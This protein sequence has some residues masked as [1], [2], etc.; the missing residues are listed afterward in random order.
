MS[1]RLNDLSIVVTGAGRGIGAEIARAFAAEGA[2]IVVADLSGESAAN[3]AG[4]ISACGGRAIATEVDVRKRASIRAMVAMAVD[5]FGG[6]DSIVNNAGIAQVR[7][8]LEITDED[9]DNVIQVN[10]RGV[11]IC[12]QEAIKQMISQ[13]RGGTVINMGSIAGKQ[14]YPTQAHYCAS[15][16]GVVALTQAGAKAFGANGIRVNAICPGIVATEMWK[17]I[18]QS[19]RDHGLTKHENEAFNSYVAMTALGRPSTP[20]DL[21]GAAVYLASG[22]SS[23]MTGQTL[24]VE[25]G[26]VFD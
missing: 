18:D 11:L 21:T 16:F 22:E 17:M 5:K 6:L 7:P 10:S 9:W 8:F 4:E 13:G 15:K 19:F 12:M 26:L 25:G 3:V 1:K 20:A 24:L 14:G 2:R 23:Y